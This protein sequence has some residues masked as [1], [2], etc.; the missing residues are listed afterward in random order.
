[1]G[2]EK[3][4][5][6]PGCVHVGALIG[7][8]CQEPAS[9]DKYGIFKEPARKRKAAVDG[10]SNPYSAHIWCAAGMAT[11][12]SSLSQ[13]CICR[14]Y[15]KQKVNWR[16]SRRIWDPRSFRF[17]PEKSRFSQGNLAF[18]ALNRNWETRRYWR[19]VLHW[20][21]SEK[22]ISRRWTIGGIS[23][24]GVSVGVGSRSCAVR[25]AKKRKKKEAV[26][27]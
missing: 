22:K 21:V 12:L 18:S 6:R 9:N 27:S 4:A 5:M 14:F 1:M 15:A 23:E 2:I 3:L 11:Y 24:N 26:E 16:T 19:E 7:Q 13:I 8:S 17:R 25:V 10:L 20:C